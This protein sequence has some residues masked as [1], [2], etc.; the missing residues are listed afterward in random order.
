V[1]A[2]VCLLACMAISIRTLSAVRDVLRSTP[3][4]APHVGIMYY[5][6]I[7]WATKILTTRAQ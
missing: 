4:S 7:I 6:Y 1:H 2:D 3:T 5:V